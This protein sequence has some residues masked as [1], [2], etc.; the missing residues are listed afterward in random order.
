MNIIQVAN[1]RWFNATA[2]YA[3]YLSKLLQDDGHNVLVLTL[4]DTPTHARALEMGLTV[5]PVDLNTNNPLRLA[6]G[7]VDLV[8]LIHTFKPEIVNCHRGEGFFLWGLLRKLGMPFQLVRTRGDQRPPRCDFFNRWLHRSVASSVVVTN[9][10]MATHFLEAMRTPEQ[11][12][13]CIHG[14]VDTDLF[15]FDPEGRE[16]VRREFGFGPDDFVIGLLGRFD[17]VKGQRE[18]A[19]SVARLRQKHGFT[20]VRLFYIGFE[21]STRLDEVRQWIAEEGIEAVTAISGKRDDIVACISALD[22]GVV[23]S[24][25]SEAIARAALEIMACKRPLV[26]TS[27][28]VMPDLVPA[29]GLFPPGDLE[30]MTTYLARAVN[31]AAFRE[32]LLQAQSKTMS[33]LTGRDFLN[34]TLNLYGSLLER[35]STT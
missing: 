5:V 24:L 13:W 3:L 14:G 35:T 9:K 21:T 8:R 29:Q 12:V 6:A 11:Q 2:W 20:R 1:V 22:L 26:S 17:E 19:Q 28:N 10:R 16:R 7:C 15:R 25:W 30:A 23:A 4:K 18:L 27:V 34:R 31:D 33:Q 32:Q